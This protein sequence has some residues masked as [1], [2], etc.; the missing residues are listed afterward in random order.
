MSW[1]VLESF[2]S[3]VGERVALADQGTSS[4][5]AQSSSLLTAVA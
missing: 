3:S 1:M 2:E 4:D 5:S